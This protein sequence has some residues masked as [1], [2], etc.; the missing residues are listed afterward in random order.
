MRRWFLSYTS[1]DNALAQALRTALQ[2]KDSGATIF[3]AP[4]TMRAGGFWQQQLADEIAKSTAF[5][6]LVG[7]TGV[8]P[9]QVMEYYEALDRHAKEPHY[10]LIMV[11]SDKTAKRTAPGLPFVRQLH[12]VLTD[13]P[14]SEATIGKLIDAASGAATRPGELWRHT[15]PYRGL[16]AMTQADSEF[17]FGRERNTVEVIRALESASEKLPVLL[18]NSGVGKSSLAQAGVLAALAR[19]AWPEKAKDIA[20]EW[21]VAFRESRRWCFL[22]LQPGPEPLRSL[23][24]P[25]LRTWQFEATDPLWAKRLVE[26]SEALEG[27]RL[28][29]RDLLSATEARYGELHQPMPPAFF[30]YIDQGEQLYVRAQESRRCRFSEILA[31]GVADPRLHAMMSFRAD[32]FGDL[33]KDEA[34]CAAHRQSNVLPLREAG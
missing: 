25:F 4:E 29:L 34:L 19:Q 23:V 17:F 10:P 32:F 1:P 30:L 3:F 31:Q 16:A 21:P 24:E 27:G 2:H 9:W 15:A 20:G 28:G 33:Q 6:L 13:D 14:A 12:W 8:G 22:L 18:G 7:E 26:W 5:V 11:V